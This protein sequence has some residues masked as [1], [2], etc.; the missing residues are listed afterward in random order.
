MDKKIFN[1]QSVKLNECNV[2]IYHIILKEEISIPK[3]IIS[4][5]TLMEASFYGIAIESKFK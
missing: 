1:N 5:E 3:Q 2:L 4:L